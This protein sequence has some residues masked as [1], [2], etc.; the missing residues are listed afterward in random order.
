MTCEKCDRKRILN[1][2]ID[3]NEDCSLFINNQQTIIS[4]QLPAHVLDSFFEEASLLAFHVKSYLALCSHDFSVLFSIWRRRSWSICLSCICLFI[5][6]VL[7]CL[8]LFFLVSGLA[9]D[10]NCGTPWTFHLTFC[11]KRFLYKMW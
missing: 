11:H 6:H 3:Y 5:L 2:S 9:A 8:F 4:K 10:C 1:Y 7:L